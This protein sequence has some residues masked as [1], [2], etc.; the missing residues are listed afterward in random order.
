M[1]LLPFPSGW[2]ISFLRGRSVWAGLLACPPRTGFLWSYHL[3]PVFLKAPWKRSR[4]KGLQWVTPLWVLHFWGLYTPILAHS[5]PLTLDSHF[6]SLYSHTQWLHLPPVSSQSVFMVPSLFHSAHLP[7]DFRVIA[8]QSLWNESEKVMKLG[9]I[10]IFPAESVAVTFLEISTS[11]E[12]TEVTPGNLKETV[13]RWYSWDSLQGGHCL[14]LMWFRPQ[15]GFIWVVGRDG[16][17]EG[18]GRII[19]KLKK[20]L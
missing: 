2:E 18:P 3:L 10:Q 11:Q 6:K 16:P 9:I 12:K 1:G 7:S 8:L 4:E 19:C 15:R 14:D 13:F 17:R 5:W 20:V